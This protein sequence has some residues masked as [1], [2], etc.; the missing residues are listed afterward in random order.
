MDR[1]EYVPLGSVVILKG[2]VQ[3]LLVVARAMNV[4]RGDKSFFFDYGGVLY[5][6]GLTGDRM[7]YFNHDNL[8][9][10]IFTGFNDEASRRMTD[11]INQYV[12]AH[13]QLVRCTPDE[14]NAMKD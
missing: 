2:A 11:I 6:E 1:T 4:K 8:D 10:V 12:E 5:P 3:P 13:P 14:W 9:E 7:A